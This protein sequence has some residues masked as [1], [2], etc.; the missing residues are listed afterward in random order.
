MLVATYVVLPGLLSLMLL[1]EL[2]LLVVKLF[3]SEVVFVLLPLY[4]LLI[5]EHEGTFNSTYPHHPW[6][7]CLIQQECHRGWG[8]GLTMSQ[9][10][11]I[12]FYW[13]A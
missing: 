3:G 6:D 7:C 9:I 1:C 10:F 4:P 13:T 2:E 12:G 11:E 8:V 5:G